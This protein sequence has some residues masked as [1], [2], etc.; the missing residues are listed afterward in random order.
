MNMD[1]NPKISAIIPTYNRSPFSPED[2]RNPLYIS[3][4]ALYEQ[5]LPPK[6]VVILDDSS[7]DNTRNVVENLQR[8]YPIKYVRMEERSGCSLARR[9]GIE[10]TDNPFLLFLDDDS[11][12]ATKNFLYCLHSAL[13]D[14]NLDAVVPPILFR[15]TDFEGDAP[16]ETIGKLDGYCIYSNFNKKPSPYSEIIDISNLHGI[17][18]AKREILNPEYFI[19]F[20]WPHN[21]GN[22]S[23]LAWNLIKDKRKLGYLAKKDAALIHLKFGWYID[24]LKTSNEEILTLPHGLKFNDLLIISNKDIHNITRD[25]FNISDFYRDRIAFSTF[26]HLLD[27]K[28]VDDIP[29]EISSFVDDEFL[30]Y[31]NLAEEETLEIINDGIEL[32]KMEYDIK[33]N[34]SL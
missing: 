13:E 34:E 27:G 11:F 17:F 20:S 5:T 28:S 18:L 14:Y 31:G 15:T 29:R 3:T 10:I 32:G 19:K 9:K 12:P 4:Y 6:E 7:E 30:N 26:L 22:E 24:D 21:W 25:G 1:M 2:V 16:I 33:S 8:K 23:Y